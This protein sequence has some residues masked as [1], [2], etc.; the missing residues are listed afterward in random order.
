MTLMNIKFEIY[1]F[2]DML[3][4]CDNDDK[5]FIWLI[6]PCILKVKPLA[7]DNENISIKYL[8]IIM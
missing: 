8:C 6:G 2:S 5:Y 1:V 7:W 4:K 3:L